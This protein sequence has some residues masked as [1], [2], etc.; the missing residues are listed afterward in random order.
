MGFFP[1]AGDATYWLGSPLFERVVMHLPDAD[2]E[3]RAPG[4]S[5]TRRY[6]AR[7]WLGETRLDVPRFEHADLVEAGVLLVEMSASPVDWSA[8]AD[9]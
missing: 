5:D 3:V 9:E 8:S 6:P 4:A 1:L 2:V 7:A